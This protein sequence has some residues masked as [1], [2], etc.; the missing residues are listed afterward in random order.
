MVDGLAVECW[1]KFDELGLLQQLG[2]TLPPG[3]EHNMR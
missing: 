1:T 3:E 2:V